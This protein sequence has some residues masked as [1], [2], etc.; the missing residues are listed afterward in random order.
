MDIDDVIEIVDRLEKGHSCL[1]ESEEDFLE[2]HIYN[3]EKKSL[4]RS[5]SKLYLP[6]GTEG[7]I[8]E[9]RVLKQPTMDGSAF[10]I[11]VRWSL[12]ITSLYYD[13]N[14]PYVPI[15]IKSYNPPI[16]SSQLRLL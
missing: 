7:E 14:K 2:D 12:G 9:A 6:K 16:D 5:D 11:C 10:E 15:R 1:V 13:G 4:E 3:Y 8:L